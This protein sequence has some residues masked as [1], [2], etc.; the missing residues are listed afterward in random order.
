MYRLRR[1]TNWWVLT[2]AAALIVGAL[3]CYGLPLVVPAM[4]PLWVRLLCGYKT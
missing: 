4:R 1:I 3:L 2:I